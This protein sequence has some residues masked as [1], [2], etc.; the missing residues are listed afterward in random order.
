MLL[1]HFLFYFKI[2]EVDMNEHLTEIPFSA[3]Q[4]ALVILN[5][6]PLRKEFSHNAV[7]I[8]SSDLYKNV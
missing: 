6:A 2:E 8:F 5:N 1:I 7:T 4:L 3:N